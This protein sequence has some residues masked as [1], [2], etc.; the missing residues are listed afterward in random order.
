MTTRRASIAVPAL[1]LLVAFGGGSSATPTAEDPVLRGERAWARRAIR[2]GAEVRADPA[3][4]EEAV[5]AW[6]QAVALDP[7]N[8]GVRARLLR[9]LDFQGR[10]VV[11]GEDTQR[12]HFDANREL[13]EEG[14]E[15]LARHLGG[16]KALD[17]LSPD[18]RAAALRGDP[19]GLGWTATDLAALHFWGA[20]AW[21]QWADR[22]GSFKAARQGVAGELRTL[23]G[24]A[25]VLDETY[26]DAGPHRFLGRLHSEAPKIP[27][28]TG[29]VDRGEAVRHLE[30]AVE[31]AP[32]EPE[33]LLFLAEALLEHRP[34]RS[35][36]ARE[37]LRELAGREPRPDH[38]LEDTRTL[39]RAREL[40]R[41]RERS[42]E[43]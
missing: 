19:D 26:A 30:R 28:F 6:R 38:L 8:P 34:R 25:L 24:T 21:G 10:Y 3:A 12:K 23:A 1:L 4:V 5:A 33:N 11:T 13:A 2:D 15:R 31:L 32:G 7:D 40:W 43:R 37:L 35:D 27:F 18:E 41:V 17:D 36:E 16:P 39:E 14:F 42:G 22:V 29:W 20:V 9:A